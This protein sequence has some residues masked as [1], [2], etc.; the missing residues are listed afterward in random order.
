M[1]KL[2]HLTGFGSGAVSASGPSSYHFPDGGDYLTVADHSDWDI[3]GSLSTTSTI[4]MWVKHDTH[5]GL[6]AYLGAFEAASD[7]WFVGHNGEAGLVF[8]YK[9]SNT[10]H[11][12]LE[13]N[14]GAI[15]DTDWH[16]FAAIMIGDGSTWEI[17]LYRDGTQYAFVSE[18]NTAT[19]A[20]PLYISKSNTIS[21]HHHGYLDGI[22]IYNGNPYSAAPVVGLTD[23]ITP[24]AAELTTDGNTSLL[25]N[26]HE[27]IVSGATG[28]GA[29]FIDS[30]NTGHTVTEVGG[31][32]RDTTTYK[33]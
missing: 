16:H 26:C 4:D 17:G 29:T 25:I 19:F 7:L 5:A 15:S 2:N 6:D 3:F 12:F 24:P 13:V 23:T 14:S 27:T 8:W 11:F 18:T 33:F 22:R 31:A 21:Y 9:E 32:I 28:S 20:S 1:L 30:G 10:T